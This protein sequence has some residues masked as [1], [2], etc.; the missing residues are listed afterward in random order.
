LGDLARAA[1]GTS[2][3]AALLD[4]RPSSIQRWARTRPSKS[5]RLLLARLAAEYG[6]P[7][8]AQRELA[9]PPEYT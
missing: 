6:L 8:A 1:G 4:V 9:H 7:V 3:L 2:R 5:V